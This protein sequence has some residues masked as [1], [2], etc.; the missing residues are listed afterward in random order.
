MK[1][2]D[3]CWADL[4]DK[5]QRMVLISAVRGCLGR[6]E[7]VLETA[8]ALLLTSKRFAPHVYAGITAICRSSWTDALTVQLRPL[9]CS[10]V[11][12]D[13]RGAANFADGDVGSSAAADQGVAVLQRLTKLA[14][15]SHYSYDRALLVQGRMLQLAIHDKPVGASCMFVCLN[16]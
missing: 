6:D 1:H 4:P 7:L 14:I 13:V 8:A 15:N 2:L 10:L 16:W 9:T 5:L 3:A 12:L 11:E